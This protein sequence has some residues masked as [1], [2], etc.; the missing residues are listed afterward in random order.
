MRVRR[1]GSCF[2]LLVDLPGA[3]AGGGEFASLGERLADA[4]G[5]V[6]DL[7]PGMIGFSKGLGLGG[8]EAGQPV[9]QPGDQADWVE[10]GEVPWRNGHF[11]ADST[12]EGQSHADL[13]ERARDTRGQ[14]EATKF[15]DWQGTLAGS[16]LI[17]RLLPEQAQQVLTSVSALAIP[18]A[19]DGHCERL[20]AGV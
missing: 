6:I 16:Q 2:Q 20:T 7:A 12:I 17:R 4:G 15:P 5:G 13:T 3:L 11:G 19:V 10:L 18:L 8:F 1:G 14:Q 9:F